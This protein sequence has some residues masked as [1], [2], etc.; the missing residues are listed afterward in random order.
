M[1]LHEPAEGLSRHIILVGAS[2]GRQW[3]VEELPGRTR[4][5]R[6]RFEYAGLYRFDK[7]EL[8]REITRREGNRPD[9]LIIKEC[10]A[11]FPGPLASYR[12]LVTGW[13]DSCLESSIRPILTTVAP[14]ASPESLVQRARAF[15]KRRLLGRGD[16]LESI[17]EYNEWVR[18]FTA[19]KSLA[20]LDL[21]AALRVSDTD[22]S[23][24]RDL[25]SGDGLHLNPQAYKILDKL[26]VQMLD[27]INWQ[28]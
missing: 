5:D 15:V 19:R 26:A 14:V 9:G 28:G 1:N 4:L 8:I 10:A 20:L 23:L 6:Y 16:R 3:R 12:D 17:G 7:S 13:V 18:R 11:Y 24:R 22:R 21:E 25:H 2:V 27:G